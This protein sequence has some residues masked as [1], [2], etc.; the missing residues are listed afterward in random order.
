MNKAQEIMERIL[1]QREQILEAFVAETGLM[2]S[3]CE[4]VVKGTPGGDTYFWVQ[5]KGKDT[6]FTQEYCN[7]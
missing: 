3:E 4:Q 7:E 6:Q 5:K 1:S 2:P